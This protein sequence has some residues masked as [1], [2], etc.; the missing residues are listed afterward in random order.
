MN[1]QEILKIKGQKDNKGYPQKL[2]MFGTL[3]Q[4]GG[5]YFN[6]NGTECSKCV[7]TDTAG[8]KHNVILMKDIPATNLLNTR[9]GFSIYSYDGNYQGKVYIGYSGFWVANPQRHQQSPQNAPQ[10]HQNAPQSTN[11]PVS[12]ISVLRAKAL[13]IAANLVVREKI[14]YT[15][16][17]SEADDFLS[18]IIGNPRT[19]EQKYDIPNDEAY[20]EI[21]I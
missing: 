19:F 12:D 10:T 14:D 20:N 15:D 17:Y 1:F 16:M 11:T 13:E 7:I 3:N 21:P 4:I 2:D 8:E 18:Y 9:Q 5:V 6:Q